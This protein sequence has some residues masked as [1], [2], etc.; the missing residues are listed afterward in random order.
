MKTLRTAT[1]GAFGETFA[2]DTGTCRFA[3]TR[4]EQ[5]INLAAPGATV[6]LTV[7]AD[8]QRVDIR[9]INTGDDAVAADLYFGAGTDAEI[10]AAFG[11]P[12]P[13]IAD[14]AAWATFMQAHA[15]NV[16]AVP[17]GGVGDEDP[18]IAPGDKLVL[19]SKSGIP[20]GVLTLTWQIGT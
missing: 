12:A 6:I 8:V 14:Q 5:G 17:A 9:V 16:L 10:A 3:E 18:A 13:D 11:G 4:R 1:V 19:H 15:P 2:S 20:A 7:P